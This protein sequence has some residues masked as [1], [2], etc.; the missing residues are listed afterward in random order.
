MWHA[1]SPRPCW[2]A[3][4][5][6]LACTVFLSIL[7]TEGRRSRWNKGGKI[8]RRLCP[9]CWNNFKAWRTSFLNMSNYGELFHSL[10]LGI[11]LTTAF[12]SMW[13]SNTATTAMMVPIVEAVLAEIRNESVS[14]RPGKD[15]NENSQVVEVRM[16]QWIV[17]CSKSKLVG[18]V[19]SP[20]LSVEPNSSYCRLHEA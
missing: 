13:I 14:N 6:N 11:M 5:W 19:R 7:T 10:M 17:K 8:S 15:T 4:N 2:R 3:K 12:L 20:I 18:D 9:C 16:L 1:K